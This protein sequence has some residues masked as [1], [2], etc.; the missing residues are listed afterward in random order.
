MSFFQTLVRETA[1]ERDALFTVPQ[2]LDGLQGRISRETYLAYLAQAYHHVSHTVPLLKLAADR[3]DVGHTRFRDALLEYVEEETGH[4]VWILNDIRNAG[5]D[6][7]AARTGPPAPET[8]AMVAFAYDYVGRIN[9]MGLFGM[10]FVLEGTSIALASSG[11]AAVAG[12]LG[13]GPECFSY[14]TSHGALDQSHMAFFAR[15]M[16]EVTEPGDQAA[17]VEVAKAVFGLFADMF[18][19]IPHDRSPAHAV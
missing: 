9:P 1:A 13:L 5:G 7:E 6:A 10:I 2:I 19:A 14:L 12:S 8:A 15:L 18:R 3:M 4:E 17:I 16:D 11:A